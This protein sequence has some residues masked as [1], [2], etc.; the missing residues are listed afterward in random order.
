MRCNSQLCTALRAPSRQ[1]W[2]RCNTVNTTPLLFFANTVPR[3]TALGS[4][5]SPCDGFC[6]RRARA[7]GGGIGYSSSWILPLRIVFANTVPRECIYQHSCLSRDLK[8]D[9]TLLSPVYNICIDNTLSGKAKL[10]RNASK[11]LLA[12]LGW[13]DNGEQFARSLI[14]FTSTPTPTFESA[15]TLESTPTIPTL[16]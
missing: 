7:A 11:F 6:D 5:I 1:G 14:S 16:H 8:H 9:A 13:V 3:D 10:K 15:P 4:E 12:E 2:I